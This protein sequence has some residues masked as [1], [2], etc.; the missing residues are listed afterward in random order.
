MMSGI[1]S[2]L[3]AGQSSSSLAYRP[4]IDGLRAVAILSVVI[5]HAF[6]EILWLSEFFC[7]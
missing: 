4:D 7:G 3:K 2:S 1:T 5:S 6:P